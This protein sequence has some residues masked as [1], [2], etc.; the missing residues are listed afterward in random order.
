M[1]LHFMSDK[2]LSRVEILRDLTAGRLTVST[3]RNFVA[4]VC[5]YGARTSNTEP[6]DLS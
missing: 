2:E 6:A 5:A 4:G 3:T 1:T